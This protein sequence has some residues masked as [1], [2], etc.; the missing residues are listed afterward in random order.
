MPMLRHAR[1]FDPHSVHRSGKCPQRA[2][3]LPVEPESVGSTACPK[4]SNVVAARPRPA[5]GH[6]VR[7]KIAEAGSHALWP[8]LGQRLVRCEIISR[9]CSATAASTCTVSREASG[10]ST[11]PRKSTPLS[12]RPGDEGDRPG[13]AIQLGDHQHAAEFALPAEGEGGGEL[14]PV[15][16]AAALHLHELGLKLSLAPH[17]GRHGG[18]LGIEAEAA[19]PLPFGGDAV[20]G[21]KGK[22][23][24]H[25]GVLF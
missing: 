20:V 19:L 7:P 5:S 11:P 8:P 18:F 10:M 16:L 15:I 24:S 6:G 21:D 13:Q 23:G 22:L 1:R 4:P 25:G 3:P 2:V 9:S 12:I 14:G 17:I